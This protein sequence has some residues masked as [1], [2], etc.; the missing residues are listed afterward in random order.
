MKP[1]I[2][3]LYH[4]HIDG[5]IAVRDVYKELCKMAGRPYPFPTVA[6][7]L[8]YMRS[9]EVEITERFGT[10]TDVL[11]TPEALELMGYAYGRRRAKEGYA[12]AEGKFAPQYHTAQGMT[13]RQVADAMYIG[14]R[15]AQKEFGIALRPV[16]SI[17]R[18]AD[19]SVGIEI[20]KIALEYDG[21]MI[22]DLVCTEAGNPPEKHY[23]A[24]KLTFDS[25]V[26]RNCHAGEWVESEPAATYM[27]RLAK[28]VETALLV[29]KCHAIGHAIPLCR[30]PD[31]VR[32][33]V[34]HQVRIDA[35]P[36]SNKNSGLIQSVRE[37]EIDRLLAEDVLYT[38]SPDDDLFMPSEQ[39]VIEECNR[40]YSFT[41]EQ[42]KKL[43]RFI[44]IL[45]DR[46]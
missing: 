28:N 14:M 3:H 23:A 27:E 39:E 11:Q 7:W 12:Y 40:V 21:E 20:A 30:R 8:E 10:V 26:S 17:G 42:C 13:M 5:S 34:E 38:V 46:S 41:K 31:L 15:K 22:L 33:A 18:A 24:Y 35:C 4:D 29:L 2:K 1:S 9:S 32:Y 25:R 43:E 36:L 6:K 45:N 44:P 37:L 19:E 16:I